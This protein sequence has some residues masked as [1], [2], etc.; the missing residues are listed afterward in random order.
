MKLRGKRV[1]TLFDQALLV[2]LRGSMLNDKSEKSR[3]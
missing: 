1:I 3:L 2:T